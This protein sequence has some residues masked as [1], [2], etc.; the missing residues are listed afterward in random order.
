MECQVEKSEVEFIVHLLQQ[1][2]ALPGDVVEFGAYK[3]DTSVELALAMLEHPS[4][5]LWLYDS[6]QGLPAKSKVDHVATRGGRAFTRGAL[7]SRPHDILRRF[8]K[9]R[10]PDPVIRAAWFEDLDP[11]NDLPQAICFAF[12]DADFYQSIKTALAL[13][14]PTLTKNG[15]IVVHDF[16]NPDLPGP[17]LAIQEFLLGQKA[18]SLKRRGRLAILTKNH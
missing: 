12:I 11:N 8:K 2:L 6:F 7:K 17:A 14:A 18:F 1:S 5:W 9:L 3:G 4:K 15:I 13:V 16:H 10:L